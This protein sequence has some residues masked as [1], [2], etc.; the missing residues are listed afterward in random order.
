MSASGDIPE[1]RD[2][3]V[4]GSIV[5]LI[6]ID[7]DMEAGHVIHKDVKGKGK[8]IDPDCLR[9]TT[10]IVDNDAMD[11]S[12]D[13][14]LQDITNG[15]LFE[16]RFIFE[17]LSILIYRAFLDEPRQHVLPNKSKK[18]QPLERRA[19]TIISD[20]LPVG[21]TSFGALHLLHVS[22]SSINIS[23]SSAVLAASITSSVQILQQDSFTY[24]SSCQI[25]S[26][27][28]PSASHSNLQRQMSTLQD[29]DRGG[30][31][32]RQGERIPSSASPS[33]MKI[34]R[35]NSRESASPVKID[36]EA[37]KALQ[38]SI[39]SLL[40]KRPS[41]DGEDVKMAGVEPKGARRTRPKRSKVC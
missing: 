14:N 32:P 40:G 23:S 36:L 10:N 20:E 33:P 6:S 30:Y 18:V 2:Y 8:A 38:E 15:M 4:P 24:S 39:A 11:V 34:Q 12:V 37:A 17:D 25:E 19:T 21:I 26:A 31:G 5:P 28:N 16:Q 27:L 29:I 7:V 22:S 41:P 3:L 1:T 13:N 9:I 35:M